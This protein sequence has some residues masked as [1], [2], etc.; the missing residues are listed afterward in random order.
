M[1]S[2]AAV[3]GLVALG[4]TLAAGVTA[5]AQFTKGASAPPVKAV[6]L[7]G[8]PVDL[9]DMV[10]GPEKPYLIILYFFSTDTGEAVAQ[11]LQTLHGKYGDQQIRIVAFG[12]REEETELRDFAE[13]FGIQY[14]LVDADAL[15]EAGWL[16]DVKNLPLTVFVQA[17]AQRTIERVLTGGGTARAMLL[18]E[19][20]EN[21]FQQRRA[22]AL[23]VAEQ[24]LEAGED[25]APAR[26]LK[27]FILLNQGK[28][29]EAESEFGAI[30]SKAG[31]ARVALEKG[32]YDGAAAIADE[33]PADPY[34]QT[35]KGQALMHKGDL[36]GA[37]QAIEK[38]GAAQD[39]PP[40]QRAETANTAG[41]LKQQQGQSEDAVEHYGEAL[42]LDHY[43]V[44]ALSNEA[45]VHREQ[46][47]LE[48][49]EA[50]LENAATIR[51]D[52]FVR[53]MLQQVQR[54]LE[55]ANDLR[56]TE[57]VRQQIAD[58]AARYQEMQESGA[59]ENRDDWTT[60]PLIVAFLPSA[61]SD[62][63]FFQRGGTKTLIQREIEARLQAD[64]EVSVVERQMLDKLLQELQLGTS[65]LARTDTQQRLGKVL[66]AG[67]LGFIDFARTGKNAMVYLRLVD[68]ETT[69]IVAQ[70]SERIED[71][72]PAAVAAP[73]VTQMLEK[74]TEDREL[75]GLIA[76]ASSEDAII[77][78][79][80]RNHGAAE[81]Q[82]FAVLEEGAPIEVGGR[83]IAHRQRQVAVIEITTLEEEYAIG[84]LVEKRDGATL[85]KGMKIKAVS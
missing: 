23:D 42:S 71:A 65:E 24:A 59:L 33:A 8:N 74:V 17:D 13:R 50:A 63:V 11:K 43:N 14:H 66:S 44:V 26:E 39:A 41:R 64:A 84:T 51:E 62:S 56:R 60:R 37:S 72:N 68:T 36:D 22:E 19:V 21:L 6:D 32:D 40:W 3:I 61:G 27:G 85:A 58:L 77:I 34:A 67:I 4:I 76:D 46:G 48:K 53:T 47:D 80:G 18:K 79:L 57:L 12:M 29:D 73:V 52:P 1:R 49:A 70:I 9:D 45:S 83:V 5:H 75:R 15:A 54:E 16:E 2:K 25:Q 20:A 30:G 69:G 82:R 35:M 7:A 38:A 55:E 81:G 10:A 28:L 78:N 31:M